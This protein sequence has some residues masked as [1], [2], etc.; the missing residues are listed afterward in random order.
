MTEPRE[1]YRVNELATLHINLRL[2]ADWADDRLNDD[3]DRQ[4]IAEHMTAVINALLAHQPP[5]RRPF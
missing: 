2:L 4:Y 1:V 5:P 3:Y